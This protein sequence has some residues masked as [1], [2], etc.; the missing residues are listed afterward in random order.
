MTIVRLWSGGGRGWRGD[1]RGG[2]VGSGGGRGRR[3]DGVRAAHGGWFWAG[4]SQ[5][6]GEV[7]RSEGGLELC[8][9]WS[10]G[11]RCAVLF[12]FLFCRRE[13]AIC[14]ISKELLED[15]ELERGASVLTLES[16]ARLLE[17]LDRLNSKNCKKYRVGGV[18]KSHGEDIDEGVL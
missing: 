16:L 14:C 10:G 15:E 3:G 2:M 12:V 18:P 1:G 13:A 4:Q 7:G 11:G 8:S 6:Q 17:H 9:A 5:M